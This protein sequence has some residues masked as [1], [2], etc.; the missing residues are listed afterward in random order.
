MSIHT[1]Q[2]SFPVS[3]LERS[4]CGI[5]EHARNVYIYT[6]KDQS[7][8]IGGL[9]ATPGITNSNLYSMIEIIV[10]CSQEYSVTSQA[11]MPIARDD[12]TLMPGT[13][14]IVTA[15]LVTINH[16]GWLPRITQL[17][18]TMGTHHE[19]FVEAVRKRDPL[20]FSPSE[21]YSMQG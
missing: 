1:P 4:N 6:A 10:I 3:E 8:I 19:A 18:D 16:Q 12:Q 20:K 11:G 5:R 2:P 17:D 9:V 13:Y 7:T 15:G 14:L 21:S